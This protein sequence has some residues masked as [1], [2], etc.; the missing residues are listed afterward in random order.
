MLKTKRI[1]SVLLTVMML[2]QAMVIPG[3]AAETEQFTDFPKNSWSEEAMTA[4]VENGLITGTSETTI[5]PRKNLTRAEFAA[6]ITR[7]FGATKTADISNFKDVK[8]GT[9][10]YDSVAKAVQMGVMNGTGSTTFDPK[11]YMKR[12]EVIL[13]LARILFVDGDDT[14]V[15]SQF[16]DRDEIDSW[17]VLAIS[18]MVSEGY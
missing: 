17:A 16:S 14:S 10:F 3:F 12:E 15:L 8:E 2:L 4:A 18:G 9:W 6:I 7:A 13:A 11:A 1:L 5:E